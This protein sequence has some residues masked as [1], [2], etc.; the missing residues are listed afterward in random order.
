M[1]HHMSDLCESALREAG[2][3]IYGAKIAIL[4]LAYLENS[5]DTRNSPTFMLV[6]ALEVLGAQ[7]IVH[8]PFVNSSEGVVLTSNI[9]EAIRD[10]DCLA[11]V[12]A[13]D[14]YKELNLS[15]VKGL[16]KTPIIVDGRNIFDR[17]ACLSKGF[18]FRGVGR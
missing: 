15:N 14:E 4:G 6:K 3:R 7:P 9:E 11:V 5:D 18:I 2:R 10:A 12:T 1:P 13:H 17:Q 16:M 8:D